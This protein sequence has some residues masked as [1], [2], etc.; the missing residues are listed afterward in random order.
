M[1]S[2]VSGK[3]RRPAT[4]PEGA[5]APGPATTTDPRIGPIEQAARVDPAMSFAHMTPH[6]P[7]PNLERT[8]GREYDRKELVW[9]VR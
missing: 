4:V 3:V 8:E 9:S 1:P 7:D 2:V 6:E 5:A